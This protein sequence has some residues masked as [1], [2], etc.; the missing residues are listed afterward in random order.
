M[1]LGVILTLVLIAI[2]GCQTATGPGAFNTALPKSGSEYFYDYSTN[3]QPPNVSYPELATISRT[4]TSFSA[5]FTRSADGAAEGRETFYFLPSGDLRYLLNACAAIVLPI[6][7]H[8]SNVI[9]NAPTPR[10]GNQ[11]Q[12]QLS[13]RGDYLGEE[14]FVING[15]TYQCVKVRKSVVVTSTIGYGASATSTIYKMYWYCPAIGFFV[16]IEEGSIDTNG[17]Q[18][19]RTSTAMMTSCKMP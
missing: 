1:K 15:I 16:R 2:C 10:T 12:G 14:S 4:D 9:T 7:S 18:V 5:A 17:K 11:A 3:G 19:G 13:Y 8:E 6:V